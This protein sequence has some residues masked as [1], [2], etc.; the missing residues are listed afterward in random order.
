MS[1]NI[2]T[3]TKFFQNT[4]YYFNVFDEKNYESSL[5][6]VSWF[7]TKI[8]DQLIAGPIL[9]SKGMPAMFQKKGK[10]RGNNVKL[11]QKR[12]KYLKI[13]TKIYKI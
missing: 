13:W 11:E 8:L 2:V 6:W 10:K 12:A 9:E 5:F 7:Y 4:K 1:R 3:C